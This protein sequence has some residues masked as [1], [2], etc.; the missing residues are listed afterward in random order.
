M[1]VNEKVLRKKTNEYALSL[2]IEGFQALSGWLHRF[3]ARH[4]LFYKT[5]SGEEKNADAVLVS[6]WMSRLPALI[7]Q[8]WPRDMFNAYEQASSSTSCPKKRRAGCAKE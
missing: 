7:S 5:V 3:K 8:Y 6:D 2:S 4:G 1:N